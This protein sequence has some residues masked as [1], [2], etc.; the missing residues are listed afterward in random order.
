MSCLTDP[1][2]CALRLVSPNV[3]STVGGAVGGFV[4]SA[5]DAVCQSFTVAAS[6]LLDAFGKAFVAIPPVDVESAGVR[7]V[8]GLSLGLAALIAALLLLG[9]V[10]RTAFTHD[11]S[12]LAQGLV[13]VGK[14][15]LAFLLTLTVAGTALLSAD[16]LTSFIVTQTFGSTQALAA[17]IAGL[18]AWDQADSA[19]LLLIFAVIGILLVIVLWFEMLLRNAAIAVLVATSPIAAAGQVSDATKG[20]WPKLAAST[21]QLI[22]LK[23]VIALVFCLGFSLTGQSSD[24]ETLLTGM[25]VLLL[26]VVAWPA[27]ARFL[28]F[29]SIQI[30]G[31][32]GLG[33]ILGFAAGR[34]T[35]PGGAPAGIDPDEFSRV[36]EA[37]TMA[38]LEGGA[39]AQRGAA[40]AGAGRTALPGGAAAAGPAGLVAAGLGMAQRAVNSLAGRMEQMAGHAGI[41]GANPYTQPA[42]TP[43]YSGGGLPSWGGSPSAA[44]FPAGT[45]PAEAAPAEPPPPAPA[46]PHSASLPTEATT[47]VPPEIHHEPPPA[48][49]A[50]LPQAG[51]TL[52]PFPTTPPPRIPGPRPADGPPDGGQDAGTP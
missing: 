34:A 32:A 40:L 14:A 24:I 50:A 25:L 12:A 9:Q 7:N 28:P 36:A 39:A 47:P 16:E 3:G 33:A 1:L 15:A 22:I 4:G 20:W 23:P 26:A 46:A 27:I 38:G 37:R 17:K 18:V 44:S 31:G 19:T 29:T 41:Q 42:G 2:S 10:I 35:G 8:Y 21:T 52:P 49:G 13:G 51:D 11:G 30:G 45:A 43:R 5:W 48:P 6:Q